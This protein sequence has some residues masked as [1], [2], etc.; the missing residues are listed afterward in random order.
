MDRSRVLTLISKTFRVDDIQQRIAEEV[1]RDVFCNVRSVSQSEFYAA[2]SAGF[3][4]QF[5]VTM[6]EP[7][8]NGE[9][10]CELD[11]QRYSIYRTYRRRDDALELY[12]ERRV[13]V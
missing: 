3:K 6:F 11:G 7:E 8:Y 1:R 10:E 5:Q 2:G 13:G 12:L 9:N 4:P